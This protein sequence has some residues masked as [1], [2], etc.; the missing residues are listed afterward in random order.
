[1]VNPLPSDAVLQAESGVRGLGFCSGGTDLLPYTTPP[2][3]KKC[4][5]A[6]GMLPVI[7]ALGFISPTS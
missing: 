7:P 1:M 2:G 3:R 6:A 5:I 4:E